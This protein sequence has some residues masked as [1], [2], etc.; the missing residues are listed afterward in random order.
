MLSSI[1][2]LFDSG[3]RPLAGPVAAERLPGILSA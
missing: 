2:Y 1:E 3:K